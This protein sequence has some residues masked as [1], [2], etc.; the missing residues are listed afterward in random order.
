MFKWRKWVRILHRDVG[1]IGAGLTIIYAISGIA[2]NHT[3]DWNPNYAIETST[4]YIQ[5]VPD[6][7]RES[8]MLIPNILSQ[9]GEK[10]KVKSFFLPDSHSVNIFVEGNTISVNLK[11]GKVK[12]EK[13][14]SRKVIRETNFL[15][16]NSPK[17]VWTL[18]ADLFAV[19]LAFLAITG[20]FM[21]PGK[22][23]IKG[24]GAWLTAL[25]FL[26]PLVFLLV[27]YYKLF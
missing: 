11:S 12:Q 10:G 1:Y 6:S 22:K 15:H 3:N 9:L 27:Y 2:V 20:L 13:V 19:A 26:I 21:I 25:G 7:M 24:R 4:E 8:Q 23:G 14:S 17:K 5:P 18:V 16:L